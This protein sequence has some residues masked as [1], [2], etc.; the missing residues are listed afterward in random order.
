[1]KYGYKYLYGFYGNAN[2]WGYDNTRNF[3]Y[4]W[5][6]PVTVPSGKQLKTVYFPIQVNSAN[7]NI[8]FKFVMWNRKT[9][10]MYPYQYLGHINHTFNFDSTG[11]KLIAFDIN[12][13]NDGSWTNED[14]TYFLSI[15]SNDVSSAMTY[16]AYVDW[17]NY[18]FR[19]G[20]FN[21]SSGEFTT[22]HIYNLNRIYNS[23]WFENSGIPSTY[24]PGPGNGYTQGPV[25][26]PCFYS[27]SAI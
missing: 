25:Y 3:E 24:G 11:Y 4:G 8:P 2:H 15:V 13:P 9:G 20:L 18:D 5:T 21:P 27:I 1:M 16:R 12:F 26:N 17:Y 22:N 6:M 7:T 10:T 23:S 14:N 19:G